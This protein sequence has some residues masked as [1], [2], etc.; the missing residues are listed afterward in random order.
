MGVL[1]NDNEKNERERNEKKV[2]IINSKKTL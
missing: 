2:P 1:R